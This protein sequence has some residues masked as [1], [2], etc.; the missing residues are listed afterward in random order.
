M[1]VFTAT[2]GTETNTFSP[3]IT[4]LAAFRDRMFWRPGEHPDYPTEQTAPLWVCR[5]RAKQYG[6]DV[7]EGSCF[8]S[9][10]A[11]PV[12]KAAYETLR[13]EVL[14]QLEQALPV[15]MVALGMHGAMV[16]Y[17]YP[18]CE[19]DLLTRVRALVGP[20]TAVGVELD[21]H[22]HLSSQMTDQADIIVTFKEYPHL[23]YLERAEELINMLE[24]VHQKR[25]VPSMTVFD[26]R[27]IDMYHTTVEPMKSYLD[28]LRSYEGR[29]GIYSISVAHGF[30][31][32]DVADMGTK[33][34][35][36][37]D[38]ASVAATT[39]ARKLGRRLFELRGQAST[40]YL[41]LHTALDQAM[42]TKGGPV[43]IADCADN[44][45]CGAPGDSTYV[46]SELQ[47]RTIGNA[48]VGPV[49][50]PA[51]V[52]IAF[53]AGEG[54]VLPLR[55]GG[56]L[57]RYSGYPI[58]AQVRV[59]KLAANAKQTFAGMPEA[60]GDAAAISFN[61]IEVV[62]T[63][64]RCQALGPDLFSSLG[65][66]LLKRKL[67][68]VKSSQHFYAGFAPLSPRVIYTADQGTINMDF[69]KI[70]YTHVARPIWPLDR[71]PFG[72]LGAHINESE[73]EGLS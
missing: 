21:L 72:D 38:Q 19:G 68:V 63:S 35:I 4:G 64:V 6:W 47:K 73:K 10:P 55:F 44:S 25:L 57:G 26:C 29:D 48:C 45:G 60:I 66:D 36:V 22:C 8:F 3:L 54:C 39:V 24:A 28:E 30:P 52:Q 7:V 71:D 1:R 40:E 5:Q 61:G 32:G 51:A 14:F 23:D 65:I 15:D 58:D 9:A 41:N 17:G 56:K 11:G 27:M 12:S 20:D 59:E 42:E 43:V 16:A 67:V 31:W 50:D 62:L 2:L 69:S 34:L 13:D 33:I 46:I 37:A 53:D 18:D 49:Y 70:P